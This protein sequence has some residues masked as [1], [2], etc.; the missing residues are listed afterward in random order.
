MDPKPDPVTPSASKHDTSAD[1]GS[2]R[3]AG[4]SSSTPSTP[5]D[6]LRSKVTYYEKVWSSGAKPK[7]SADT[8]D[9]EQST[10]SIDVNAFEKR[11]QEERERKIHE[12]SPRIDIRLRAT[13][14]PSPRPFDLPVGE[15]QI[16]VNIKHHIENDGNDVVD[17]ATPTVYKQRIVTYE[18]ISTQK[19]IREVNITRTRNVQSP[20]SSTQRIVEYTEMLGKSPS[21]E[22]VGDDSAYHSH[23]T[24][25]GSGAGTPTSASVSSSNASLH[26][27]FTTS[28]ENVFARRTPSRERIFLERAGSEPP[29]SLSSAGGTPLSSGTPINVATNIVYIGNDDDRPGKSSSVSPVASG[30]E[31]IRRHFHRERHE[32]SPDNDGISPDWYNEYQAHSFHTQSQAQPQRMDFKRSNSQ[33]DNHIRQIRGTFFF[34]LTHTLFSGQFFISF[35]WN[36][37]EK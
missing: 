5:Q 22:H 32:S 3:W 10:F 26:Q 23:R 20:T 35:D 15:N 31:P 1:V 29:H 28:D 4:E 14:Q 18:K 30:N 21:N 11:L 2:I 24:R 8:S 36:L 34:S 6:N 9:S 37:I 19:S 13:P 33:Y 7:A 16:R 25:F 17:H 12:Q 27:H